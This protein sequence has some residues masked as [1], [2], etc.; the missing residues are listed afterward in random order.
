MSKHIYLSCCIA[1]GNLFFTTGYSYS[2]V[3]ADSSSS[4]TLTNAITIQTY[5]IVEVR[6]YNF[7]T[8]IRTHALSPLLLRHNTSI[9]GF[10]DAL[11]NIGS[12]YMRS[13]GN[14]M[15]NGI[16]IR[17]FGP[18]RTSVLWNGIPINN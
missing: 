5:S 13:Y 9:S 12:V 10:S 16:T 1:L 4:D 8:G 6:E 15:L 7:A 18:E 17:G 3:N 14:G 11:L 2:Q